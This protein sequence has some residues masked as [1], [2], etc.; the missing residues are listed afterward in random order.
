MN[1]LGG[2]LHIDQLTQL[3]SRPFAAGRDL[4]EQCLGIVVI[5]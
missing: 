2:V 5:V 4:V 3:G 1:P